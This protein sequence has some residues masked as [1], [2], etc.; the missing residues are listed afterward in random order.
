MAEDYYKILGVNKK[1][2]PD[3][4][5]KAYRKLALKY[6]PDK[7]PDNKQA[8]EQFKK[9]SEAYAVIS[10]PEKRKQYDHFGSDTF[11]Q[12]FSQEDIFRE[13]DFSKIF[14]DMGVGGS[15]GDF[16][17]FFGRGGRKRSFTSRD[18]DSFSEL[19][20]RTQS[21]QQIR[22][23]GSNLEYVLNISLEE[24]FSGVDKTVSIN[25]GGEVDEIRFK[26]PGG[27]NTGQK[28][29]IPGKG[30]EGINGGSPGDLY[31]KINVMPHSVFTRE[32]DDI[33]VQRSITFSEATLGK[34]IDV[35]TLSGGTKRLK[36]PAGTQ[37]NTKI[38]MKGY[39]MP[40]FRSTGKGD[41]YIK[42]TVSVP[43]TL[44]KKQRDLIKNLSEEGL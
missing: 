6:H 33:Y 40:H 39:G 23:K 16:T 10:D 24:S 38:R 3:D 31:I 30:Q 1:S 14:R 27:I 28:L 20:G 22:R 8:E 13:F 34:S 25:K 4:I 7:N 15:G 17:T 26:V 32:V 43:K 41:E 5:K 36:I 37:N 2:S 9:I 29:R 12:K 21:S 35:P 19:F 18:S 11:S 44:T 42:I